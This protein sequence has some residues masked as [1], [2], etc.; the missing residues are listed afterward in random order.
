MKAKALSEASHGNEW[1]LEEKS[2]RGQGQKGEN[3]YDQGKSS[4][5]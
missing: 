4:D 3:E 5:D 1:G 2:R